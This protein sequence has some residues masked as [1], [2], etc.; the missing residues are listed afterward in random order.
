MSTPTVVIYGATSYTATVHLIP[1]LAAHPD[2]KSGQFKLVLAGRNKGKIDAVAKAVQLPDGTH[3]ETVALS[4]DDR[5][6]VDAL[7]QRAS[8]IINLAGA[9]GCGRMGKRL[10]YG[11]RA[12][13]CSHS[14]APHRYL[15][16][17]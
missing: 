3:P 12:G 11:W 6:A 4:L 16:L 5:P 15:V 7:V 8:V 2:L 10:G 17:I 14:A 1:Y 13:H 9:L